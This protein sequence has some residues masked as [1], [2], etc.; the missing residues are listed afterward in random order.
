MSSMMRVVSNASIAFALVVVHAAS[1]AFTVSALDVVHTASVASAAS[2][3]GMIRAASAAYQNMS[4]GK[5]EDGDTQ[6]MAMRAADGALTLWIYLG[7]GAR[8]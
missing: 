8:P 6:N 3:P 4:T 2:L 5:L 1:V 7:G